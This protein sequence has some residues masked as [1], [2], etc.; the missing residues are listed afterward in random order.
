MAR[1]KMRIT[2]VCCVFLVVGLQRVVGNIPCQI[3][4]APRFGEAASNM[5]S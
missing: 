4:P 3:D 2:H 1:V 5:G